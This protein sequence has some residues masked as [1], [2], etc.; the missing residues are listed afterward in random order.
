MTE[1]TQMA[2]QH[3]RHEHS[4]IGDDSEHQHGRPVDEN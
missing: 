4:A 2:E 3:G 1:P